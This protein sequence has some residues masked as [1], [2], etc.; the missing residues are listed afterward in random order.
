M[1][2]FRNS[3]KF[4]NCWYCLFG[5]IWSNQK[6][7]LNSNHTLIPLKAVLP[8]RE[9]EIQRLDTL[10]RV[11]GRKHLVSNEGLHIIGPDCVT[12]MHVWSG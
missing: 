11:E 12:S 9:L 1:V 7:L 10:D 8:P 2:D 4:L 3:N 6:N 5:V